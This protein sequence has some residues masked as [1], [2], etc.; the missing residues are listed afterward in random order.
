MMNNTAEVLNKHCSPTL[1]GNITP[2]YTTA[3]GVNF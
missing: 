1:A 2:H 3:K